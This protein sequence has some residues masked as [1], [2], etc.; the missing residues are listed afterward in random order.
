MTANPPM[1]GDEAA[2]VAPQ[3]CCAHLHVHYAPEDMPNGMKRDRWKCP[4]C[5]GDL[6]V[7]PRAAL[8]SPPGGTT[9]YPL[10]QQWMERAIDELI[11]RV[12]KFE[13]N[14]SETTLIPSREKYERSV[15]EQRRDIL[16]RFDNW[17]NAYKHLAG[18]AVPAERTT[19]PVAWACMTHHGYAF[20]VYLGHKKENLDERVA[21]LN[22]HNSDPA[23]PFYAA[24]LYAHPAASALPEVPPAEIALYYELL[25]QVGN[26]YPGETRHQTALRYLRQAENLDVSATSL[27]KPVHPATPASPSQEGT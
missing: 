23:K 25:W 22:K 17:L 24:P 18:R 2:R 14:V 21:W 1:P 4:D 19:E 7:V 11:E 12:Q 20:E 16:L 26:V 5:S 27:T 8:A 3:A 13:R 9:P 10:A 15:N 6:L